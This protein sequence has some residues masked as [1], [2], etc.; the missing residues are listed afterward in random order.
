MV[1]GAQSVVAAA[2]LLECV[3]LMSPSVAVTGRAHAG[4]GLGI[5]WLP[6][7]RRATSSR[8]RLNATLRAVTAVQACGPGVTGCP[9]WPG[10]ATGWALRVRAGHSAM[11]AGRQSRLV[12]V[13]VSA[14]SAW[15]SERGEKRAATP[16]PPGRLQPSPS[17]SAPSISH[18]AVLKQ[19]SGL[20]FHL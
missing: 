11:F 10:S 14:R 16:E 19:F 2:V 4:S 8:A 17:V 13:P 5:S 15:L 20:S 12:S 7:L 6:C 18:T 3:R 9:M 1:S